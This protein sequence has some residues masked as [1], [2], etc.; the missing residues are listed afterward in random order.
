ML[1]CTDI[2]LR[3]EDDAISWTWNKFLG[4]I[5]IKFAYEALVEQNVKAYPK[6][7]FTTIWKLQIPVKIILFVW[8]SLQDRILSGENYMHRG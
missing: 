6:W 4:V 5:T 8:L 7:W 2:S 3:H 1:R